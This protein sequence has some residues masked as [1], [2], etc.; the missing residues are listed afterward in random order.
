MNEASRERSRSLEVKLVLLA[1]RPHL[2]RRA[3]VR[4]SCENVAALLML[5]R[6]RSG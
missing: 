6:G 1:P 2:P 3:G 4:L 5:W